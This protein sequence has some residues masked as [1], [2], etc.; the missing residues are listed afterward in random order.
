MYLERIERFIS[1]FKKQYDLIDS[2]GDNAI[3]KVHKKALYLSLIDG[4]SGVVYPNKKHRDRFVK[5]VL[6]FGEWDHGE[7]ISLPHLFRLLSLNPDPDLESLRKFVFSRFD[8]WSSGNIMY[9]DNDVTVP[10]IKKHWPKRKNYDEPINGIQVD[11]L[12]HVHLLYT[13]RNSLIHE[14]RPLGTDLEVPEDDAPYYMSLMER[15][16][17]NK[18]IHWDLIYPTVFFKEICNKIFTNLE[19]YF[20]E[21]RI[22]PIEVIRSGRYWLKELN[23]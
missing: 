3:Y 10:D 21:N 7:Y 4:L 1:H 20:K 15:P 18:V 22:D 12:K 23:R 19:A 13:F 17:E 2:I 9:L 14:F 11:S 5:F 6:C 8:T 16:Y